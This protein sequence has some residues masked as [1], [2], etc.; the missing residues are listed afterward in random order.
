MTAHI[1]LHRSIRRVAVAAS[2]ITLI[3]VGG[4]AWAH[5]DDDTTA[6]RGDPPVG[7]PSD[8]STGGELADGTYI[9]R[10]VAAYVAPDELVFSPSARSEQVSVPV[11]PDVTV[12]KVDGSAG[13]YGSFTLA[14]DDA[15]PSSEYRGAAGS[16]RLTVVDGFVTAIVEQA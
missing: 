8:G 11:S 6:T 5:A 16:Y 13:S 3:G 12:T 9:G 2:A 14:F 10:I 7:A 15:K 4:F 1:D